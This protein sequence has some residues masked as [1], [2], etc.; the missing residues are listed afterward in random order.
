MQLQEEVLLQQRVQQL[1]LQ[2]P[3]GQAQASSAEPQQVQLQQEVLPLGQ[4]AQASFAEPQQMQLH[5]G[6]V[7]AADGPSWAA[8]AN[9]GSTA[10]RERGLAATPPLD[11][12]SA[13]TAPAAPAPALP[14]NAVSLAA[15]DSRNSTT[16]TSTTATRGAVAGPRDIVAI[17]EPYR[18]P[19]RPVFQQS[20]ACLVSCGFVGSHLA[21][22]AVRHSRAIPCAALLVPQPRGGR[23]GGHG[24][25]VR[26]VARHERK[27]VLY[28]FCSFLVIMR[29]L[30]LP[31]VR[32]A[33]VSLLGGR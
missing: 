26:V 16:A 1:G 15:A 19:S 2:L 33:L 28:L 7:A 32:P 23:E 17:R 18:R 27:Y 8:A 6:G 11:A 25:L 10:G 9:A 24:E 31:T 30:L 22:K 29:G 12:L 3:D 14:K 21:C 13:A 20:H 4:Q 5:A